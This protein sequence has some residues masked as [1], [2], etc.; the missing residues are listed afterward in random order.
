MGQ[1]ASSR[2]L[3]LGVY[4][5]AFLHA[6]G[7]GMLA[8]AI[9]LF[10]QHL[11]M[12]LVGIGALVA[13]RGV[14]AMAADVPAG[15]ISA[16]L[17]GRRGILIGLT[18]SALAGLALA[19]SRSPL[20]LFLAIPLLGVGM[21]TWLTSRITYV[22]DRVASDERGRALATVGG[23]SRIGMTLGPI[24]GGL[25]SQRWGIEA[26]LFGNAG[27]CA[28]AAGL[29]AFSPSEQRRSASAAAARGSLR[30]LLWHTRKTLAASASVAVS[31]VMIRNAR[32]LLVPLWG[33][34]LGLGL[35]EIGWVIGLASALDMTLFRPVGMVMD[36]WGR[37]W[38]LLP[39]LLLLSLCLAL[40]PLTNDFA[41]FLAVA[42]LGGLGNG[43]GSG[44]VMTMGA[45]LA[46]EAH[47]GEFIG[48][49][50]LVSDTG[51]VAAPAIVGAVAQAL[52]LGAA[53]LASAGVGVVGACV[54]AVLVPE[55]LRRIREERASAQPADTG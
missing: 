26:A 3:L 55:S 49:W 2:P 42:L 53:F 10:A 36:R 14:G 31:L 9:P 17:G 48:L 50:R 4:G 40:F 27:M 1:P 24:V 20:H 54:M 29:V 6:V 23:V 47:R 16:R 13:L 38:T 25:M 7:F 8:P 5:P 15:A 52:G 35:A 41:L 45:D 51:T 22:A 32:Q 21:A 43:L 18:V 19:S 30:R 34:S 33:A 46:P 44:A 11:G 28:L 37:K 39:C 12:S